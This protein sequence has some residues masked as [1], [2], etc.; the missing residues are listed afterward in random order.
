MLASS[1]AIRS[2]I[3]FMCDRKSETKTNPL[4]IELEGITDE[5]H[6]NIFR[7][8]VA[9]D[10]SLKPLRVAKVLNPIKTITST[11]RQTHDFDEE[12]RTFKSPH[13]QRGGGQT[14]TVT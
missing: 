10:T 11:S 1:R 7:K 14:K 6:A 3:Q 12:E 13:I 4:L 9:A 5:V 2:L 8:E